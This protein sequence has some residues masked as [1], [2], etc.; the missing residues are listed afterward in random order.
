MIHKIP[1]SGRGTAPRSKTQY[2]FFIFYPE[3]EKVKVSSNVFFMFKPEHEKG[4][5]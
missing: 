5:N 1:V 4:K 2:L 3:H